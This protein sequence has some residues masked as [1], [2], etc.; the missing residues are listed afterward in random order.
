MIIQVHDELVFDVEEPELSQL[1]ALVLA[2][3]EGVVDYLVPLT[4]DVQIGKNWLELN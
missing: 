4:V 1:T 3:M 2:E